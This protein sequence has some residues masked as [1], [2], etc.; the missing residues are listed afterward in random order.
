MI[1][2]LITI[3]GTQY[4][5]FRYCNVNRSTG[6]YTQSSSFEAELDSPFGRHASD[7]TVGKEV[8]IYADKDNVLNEQPLGHW[9]L[10]DNLADAVVVDSGSGANNGTASANTNTLTINGKINQAFDFGTDI[11]HNE[12]NIGDVTNLEFGSSDFTITAWINP[13]IGGDGDQFIFSKFSVVGSRREYFFA[14]SLFSTLAF[15]SSD[16]GTGGVHLFTTIS[17]AN[18]ITFG[19]WNHVAVVKS[20]TVVKFYV[21]GKDT[22]YIVNNSHPTT[23]F[24]ST[25]AAIIGDGADLVNGFEGFIDDVRVYIR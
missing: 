16:D 14:I 18:V 5:D 9:R 3:D 1:D 6:D 4:S 8:V 7:F 13:A 12:V 15:G 23:I 20:G 11:S 25:A 2:V 22:G 21:N 10:N 19:K 17:Q 24:S